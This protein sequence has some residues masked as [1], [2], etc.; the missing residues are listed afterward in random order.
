MYQFMVLS[1]DDNCDI[2]LFSKSPFSMG[3]AGL[4]KKMQS[5]RLAATHVAVD[6]RINHCDT[7]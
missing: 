6:N 1:N 2:Q 5:E 4:K 7:V 3:G